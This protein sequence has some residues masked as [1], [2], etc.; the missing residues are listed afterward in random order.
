MNDEQKKNILSTLKQ[1]FGHENFRDGQEILI[2]C[3]LSGRDC[4]GIMPTG[5]GKSVC[6][7]LPAIMAD[8]ITLVVS[9][10]IS[11]MKD[12]VDALKENGIAAAYINSSLTPA[13]VDK[14][15]ELARNGKYKIIYIAPERLDMPSFLEFAKSVNIFMV[16]V[17]EAHCVSQWGQDFRPSY[18][19]I[20]TF[21]NMLNRRPIVSAFTATA[22]DEIRED[23]VHLLGLHSP[24]TV[25]TGF[26]RE[27]LFFGVQ[28]PKDKY[29]ALLK[30]L[31][32]NKDKSGIIYCSTR[33][34][35]EQVTQKL[36]EDGHSATRYHAGLSEIERTQNQ[37]DF[38]HDRKTIM[39]AT[40]AFGMGIDKSNVSFVIHYNMPKNIESY[41]QEAGRAGRDGTPSDCILFFAEKDVVTNRFF[42]DK[43]SD[44]NDLPPEMIEALKI[45]DR[46]LLKQITH[47]CHT[48]NCLREYILH[49]FKDPS[50]PQCDNCSNC[51][52]D[53]QETDITQHAQ[54][55]LSCIARMGE[56]FGMSM[57]IAVLRGSK[58]QKVLNWRLDQ[59]KTYGALADVSERYLK[60]ITN[61]LVV[62]EYITLTNTEFPI[63]KLTPK[64]KELLFNGK[65]IFMKITKTTK[66]DTP[67]E[68]TSTKKSSTNH[69]KTKDES[70]V[71]EISYELLKKLK[72][73]RMQIANK[74]GVPAF[75][76]FADSSLIDMCRR[77]PITND[78]FLKISGV[79]KYKLDKYGKE[80]LKIINEFKNTECN[81]A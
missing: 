46:E 59:I 2:D 58:S 41:Y 28:K 44:K 32:N 31:H 45:N 81:H 48:S 24:E 54:K 47:Y 23:I 52:E 53:F 12:Q 29:F 62:E 37:E 6:Y 34:T 80:F 51:K 65:Q 17:D 11:L 8:G 38:L 26:N 39:V 1:H 40:N 3:V 63:A 57:V 42:I 5:A 15:I 50:T 21:I 74:Q 14:V 43:T 73:V 36:T 18:R 78:E 77:M 35:V 60:D 33:D 66:D 79:G 49:Y 55:I 10:L 9:P 61:H 72:E 75:V 4:L 22:T 76:I 67:S 70:T 56:R 25:I 69:N 64:S 7:Q 30:Y 13:Q 16:T 20:T 71:Y 19:K 27:N 68:K